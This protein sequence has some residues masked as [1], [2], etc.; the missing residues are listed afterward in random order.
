MYISFF[1]KVW[2]SRVK[3]YS[4]VCRGN[5][6]R[7]ASGFDRLS[8]DREGLRWSGLDSRGRWLAAVLFWFRPRDS[9][10]VRCQSILKHPEEGS[11]PQKEDC[12]VTSGSYRVGPV[13]AGGLH[14][15]IL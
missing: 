7:P 3:V 9:V 2:I 13:G 1:S 4:A 11:A 5:S 10:C 14:W 15:F 12:S 8:C 6:T